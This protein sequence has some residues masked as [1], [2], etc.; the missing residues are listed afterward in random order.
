MDG[1]VDVTLY[2][3]LILFL[4]SY[5][6]PDNGCCVLCNKSNLSF[7]DSVDS[8]CWRTGFCRM[9]FSLWFRLKPTCWLDSGSHGKVFFGIGSSLF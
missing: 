7:F 1:I 3:H 9:G 8:E 4:S 5:G 2:I 6:N